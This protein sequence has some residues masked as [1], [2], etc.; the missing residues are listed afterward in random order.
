[1]TTFL[2]KLK[3]YLLSK[4]YSDQHIKL[5]L[6]NA[7]IFLCWYHGELEHLTSEHYDKFLK[8]LYRRHYP[9]QKIQEYQSILN[10]LFP[11]IH[12]RLII[13]SQKKLHRNDEVS[14]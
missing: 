5:S 14:S 9:S 13:K 10:I 7:S 2:R 6:R 12:K 3:L 1:M 4:N 11:L 8:V